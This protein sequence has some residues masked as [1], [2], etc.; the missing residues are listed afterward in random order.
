MIGQGD[1]GFLVRQRDGFQH[2]VGGK[3]GGIYSGTGD[4]SDDRIDNFEMYDL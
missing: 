3:Y 2:G 4:S 1:L